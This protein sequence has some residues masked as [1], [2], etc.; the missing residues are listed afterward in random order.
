MLWGFAMFHNSHLLEGPEK[1]TDYQ[2]LERKKLY[3]K[4]ECLNFAFDN[5]PQFL[6]FDIFF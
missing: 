4:Q 3:K 1:S 2:N 6:F 5:Y